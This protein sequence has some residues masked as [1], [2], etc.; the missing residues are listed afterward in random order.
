MLRRPAASGEDVEAWA[1]L[2][3]DC[4]KADHRECLQ[5]GREDSLAVAAVA[6]GSTRPTRSV[7]SQISGS[8]SGRSVSALGCAC[9]G[10]K[11]PARFRDHR[12]LADITGHLR[13]W[14]FHFCTAY[15][16][17]GRNPLRK[18]KLRIASRRIDRESWNMQLKAPTTGGSGAGVSTVRHYT[19]S[20]HL[21]HA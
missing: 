15:A 5:R 20:W 18:N 13:R 14:N 17:S 9:Y 4:S 3:F 12:A 1:T 8:D 16:T 10:S 11:Y 7:E 6:I 19:D 21:R 2:E